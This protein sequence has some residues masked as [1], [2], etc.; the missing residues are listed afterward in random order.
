MRMILRGGRN[1]EFHGGFSPL[2]T[3]VLS[4]NTYGTG[5]VET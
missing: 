4:D 5:A 3:R 1:R 2:F